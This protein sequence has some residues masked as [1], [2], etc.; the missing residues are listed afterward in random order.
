MKM[1]TESSSPPAALQRYQLHGPTMGSRYTA[2]F[3]APPDAPQAA[4]ARDLFTPVD[5]VDRQMS[6]WRADSDLCR[7]NRAPL[8]EWLA[9]PEKL[10]EVLTAAVRIERESEG[11]FDIN[12]GDLVSAWGFGPGAGR[13]DNARI[14]AL[15]DTAR[16][17]AGKAL[18]IDTEHRRVRKHAAVSLDLSGIA[19]GFAVDE[20]ARCLDGYGIDAWLVGIDG[21]MRARGRKSDGEPWALALER[22][23]HGVREVA[24]VTTLHDAAIATS[25]DYR[26]WVEIGDR[27]LSHT[28]QPGRHGP[29]SNRLAAVSV[30]AA[31]SML[32][33]AWATAL[34]VLGE[35]AGPRLA[36]KLGLQALFVL[37]DGEDLHE[38]PVGAVFAGS[39]PT[40][41]S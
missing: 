1:S 3:Y 20:L 37:R 22:P 17:P 25:G 18:E 36:R 29:V 27:K 9:V 13:P 6:T 26:H 31:S 14:A 39:P 16:T 33:D 12:V 2:V 15:I 4:I 19:K 30:V 8:G 7:L 32:A 34:M 23:V 41:E 35:Q 28:M 38:L 5:T 21:E 10:I 40:S 11:A 24:G